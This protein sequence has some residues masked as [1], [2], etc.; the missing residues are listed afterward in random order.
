MSLQVY[1]ASYCDAFNT[2]ALDAT[3]SLF[4]AQALFEMPLLGQRLIGRGE[5]AAGLQRM[6]D[7]TE[8]AAIAISGAKESRLAIIAEG[9]MVAKL[10]RDPSAVTIPLAMTLEA[11]G[12]RISRL[13]TYLDARPYRLWT[14][15][16]IFAPSSANS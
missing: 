7:V 5:I 9:R 3:L 13:S 16:P 2:R 4:S 15:G 14:D 10:K 8:S 1:L 11:A 12:G 6:F